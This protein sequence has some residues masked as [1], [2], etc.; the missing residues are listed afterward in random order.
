MPTRS[1][2][3]PTCLDRFIGG[4]GLPPYFELLFIK[5]RKPFTNI[6]GLSLYKNR[7]KSPFLPLLSF[8]K[9]ASFT[10]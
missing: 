9:P 6:H 3:A 4:K 8:D 10:L 1:F 7:S 5:V 2:L